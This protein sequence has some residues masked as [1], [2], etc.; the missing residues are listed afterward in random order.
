[1]YPY[2]LVAIGGA[3]GSVARYGTGVLVGK[4]WD[5]TFPLATMLINVAGS[6]AMGLFIGYLVRTTPGWQ[7]DGRLFVA[8]GVLG[9]FTTFSSFSLDAISML[10]RGDVGPALFY[11]VGSVVIGLAALFGGLVVMRAG[12]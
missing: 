11:V 1:M 6:L 8:I 9:G 10:E 5:S 4:V 12:A 2:L 7:A 3:L